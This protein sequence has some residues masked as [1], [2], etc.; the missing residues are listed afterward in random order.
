MKPKH[1][2]A[3]FVD[4]LINSCSGNPVIKNKYHI[5]KLPLIFNRVRLLEKRD[6]D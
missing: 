4:R 2:T 1:L 6:D 3:P 5:K